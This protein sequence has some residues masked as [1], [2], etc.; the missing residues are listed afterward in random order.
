MQQAKHEL[1]VGGEQNKVPTF[2][3][4]CK[5]YRHQYFSKTLPKHRIVKEKAQC[6]T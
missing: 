4:H 1:S 3:E 2:E 6:F 5:T